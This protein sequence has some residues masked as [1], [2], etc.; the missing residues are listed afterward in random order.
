MKICGIKSKSPIFLRLETI[1]KTTHTQQILSVLPISRYRDPAL[2]GNGRNTLLRD[3]KDHPVS[4]QHLSGV[5]GDAKSVG[6]SVDVG[7]PD[8][9]TP[10]IGID[11]VCGWTKAHECDMINLLVG[12]Y[13]NV[14]AEIDGIWRVDD[15]GTIGTRSITV[16]YV[17]WIVNLGVI[18]I[19]ATILAAETPSGREDCA[20][21]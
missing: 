10:L 20:V 14:G 7:R 11:S 3:G 16:V 13:L 18:V 8:G 17:R 6:V 2:D 5:I 1:H 9:S 19:R 21:R 12:C 15:D 4:R